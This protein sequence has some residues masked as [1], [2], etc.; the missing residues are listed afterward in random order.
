LVVNTTRLVC[1]TNNIMIKMKKK[2]RLKI[3]LEMRKLNLE[4]E[5]DSV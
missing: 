2:K 5:D 1:Y 3:Y 4:S